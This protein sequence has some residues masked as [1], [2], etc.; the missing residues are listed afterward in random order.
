MATWIGPGSEF[1]TAANWN[2]AD[3][4]N[5]AGETA[6][7]TNNSAPTS[8]TVSSTTTVGGFTFDALAPTHT[9][10]LSAQA[11]YCPSPAPASSTIPAWRKTCRLE[12]A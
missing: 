2:P 5:S 7:F 8:V 9:I 10:G 11:R 3:V 6:T 12:R 1:T 4:P